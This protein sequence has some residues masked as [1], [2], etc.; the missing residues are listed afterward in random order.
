[1]NRRLRLGLAVLAAGALTAGIALAASS[2]TVSTNAAGSI[3]TSSAVLRGTINPNGSTTSYRF[4]YGLSTSYGVSTAT[5][6]AGKGTKPVSVHATASALLPGT[7]YHFRLVA[8]NGSGL[9][10]GADRSF[11]T[12]GNPPPAVATGPAT[13]LGPF[14]VT[15]TGLVDPHGEA[16]HYAFQYGLTPA[17]GALSSG[18]TVPAGNTVLSVAEQ[19]TGLQPGTIF[20]Y[21]IIASH[22]LTVFAFGADQTFMTLPFPRPVPKVPAST[23]PRRDRRAPYHFTTFGHINGPASTRPLQCF[24]NVSIRFFNGRHRVFATLVPVQPDCTF[25]LETTFRHLP[26]HRRGHNTVRLKIL[27]HFEGNGYLAPA[28]ARTEFVTLG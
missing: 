2:P 28:N 21:R 7:R 9:S 13:G 10:V 24:G 4:D 19:L 25:S 22:G 16:T 11:T 12:S 6:S 17:Y 23:N 15:V 1:M 5:H 14:S 26:R 3:T 20:H 27:I 18:G 8:A